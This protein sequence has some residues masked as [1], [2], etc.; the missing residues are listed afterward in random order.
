M[1]SSEWIVSAGGSRQ[2]KAI[3]RYY[4]QSGRMYQFIGKLVLVLTLLGRQRDI[5]VI[6]ALFLGSS[7]C[8]THQ[9]NARAT[10]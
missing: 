7:Y 2:R 3:S 6:Q 4:A 8:E 9:A 1:I 5:F 10:G